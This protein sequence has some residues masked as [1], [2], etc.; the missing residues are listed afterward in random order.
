MEISDKIEK[1]LMEENIKMIKE[2][3]NRDYDNEVYDQLSK[4]YNS[5]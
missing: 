1:D 5:K 3:A 2:I 4:E